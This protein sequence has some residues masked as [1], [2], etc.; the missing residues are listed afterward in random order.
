MSARSLARQARALL[1]PRRC[2]FC[3]RVL[4][5]VPVCEDCAPELDELRRRPTM[6][7]HEGG[8]YLGAL[9]GAA[10]PYEY[11][12]CVRRAVLNA[13]YS[14]EP[15]TAEELGVEL[16][17]CAFGSEVEMHFTQPKPQRVAGLE[18]GYQCIVPVPATNRVR[19]YNVPERMARP[20]AE[21]IGV[22]LL[23]NAL[24]R[25]RTDRR[26]EGLTLDERLANVAGAFRVTKPEDIEGR[27]VLLID[28]VITTGATAA[29][30]AQTLLAAGAQSVFAVSFAAV[31]RGA[32]IRRK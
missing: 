8:H 26:Q 2:P 27:S 12:G 22:P 21:A 11:E 3:G 17:R 13:K 1:Y 29:A 6:R 31:G 14:A 15:W 9:S 7:L 25:V 4:G 10:A 24:E 18:L 23:P 5:T 20:L 30:C 28:D 32:A 19:G 16:A